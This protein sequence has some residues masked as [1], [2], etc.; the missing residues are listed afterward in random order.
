MANFQKS[1]RDANARL[2]SVGR[3]LVVM[4]EETVK[5]DLFGGGPRGEDLVVDTNDTSIA[6]VSQKPVARTGNLTTYAVTGLK[7]GVTKLEARL[8]NQ[9]PRDYQTQRMLWDSMPVW[10]S[11][12]LS[13]MGA[14]YR[15]AAEPWGNLIYGS[16]NPRWKH[17][18]WTSMAY[19]GCGPTS[20]AI[21]LDYLD[22]L[23]S[24]DKDL[25]VCLP[26]V[27]PLDTMK[28][29]S[30]YGRAADD[31]GN[32]SGTSGKIMMDNIS[33]YWPDYEAEQV[34]DLNHAATLLRGN[35][36]LVFLCKNCTTYKLVKGQKKPTT[37]PGHF[38]V[39]V[40]VENDGKTFW[41]SDPSLAHTTYISSDQLQGSD[42]WRVYKKVDNQAAQNPFTLS[43]NQSTASP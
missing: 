5:I 10:A 34:S 27:S 29:T 9:S 21:V 1:P 33:T 36:P 17:V 4:L 3:K 8:Y 30:Q 6:S 15:Q 14:E 26:G 20:L 16:T 42:I 25:P 19:A 11:L 23:N 43:P 28:Y 12:Q 41:I 35:T 37:F 18:N 38:M 32:P 22:R 40:G 24:P 13:V 39:L 31:K 7:S 2:D